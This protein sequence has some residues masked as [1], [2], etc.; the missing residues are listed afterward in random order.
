[1]S[2]F[3]SILACL[4]Y[5]ALH[6]KELEVCQNSLDIIQRICKDSGVPVALEKVDGP[7][8][9]LSFVGIVLDTTKMEA[10]LPNDKL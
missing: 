4:L 1:M 2:A 6:Q 5:C 3:T 7:T 8:T 9:T 10:R